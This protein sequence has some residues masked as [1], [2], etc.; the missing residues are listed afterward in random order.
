MANTTRVQWTD[1]YIAKQLAIVEKAAEPSKY[2][3]DSNVLSDETIEAQLSFN[4]AALTNYP[5]ALRKLAEVRRR[6]VTKFWRGTA[7]ESPAWW[8]CHLCEWTWKDGDAELHDVGCP[9]G[10]TAQ[11]ENP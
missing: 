10:S 4:S 7:P 5:A 8:S 6:T 2:N 11:E 9:M 3:P 1:A